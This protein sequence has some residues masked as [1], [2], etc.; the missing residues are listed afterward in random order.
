MGGKESTQASSNDKNKYV[1]RTP[2]EIR[3]I[4]SQRFKPQKGEVKNTQNPQ[5]DSVPIIENIQKTK[6]EIKEK[7]DF[8]NIKQEILEKPKESKH[9]LINKTPENN[10]LEV[11][12]VRKLD[13]KREINII[14]KREMMEKDKIAKIKKEE[15]KLENIDSI[16]KEEVAKTEELIKE[17]EEKVSK[18]EKP[19]EEIIKSEIITQVQEETKDI[20][21]SN[22]NQKISAKKEE[23]TTADESSNLGN[24]LS[25]L[26]ENTK[27]IKIQLGTTL[28]DQ[29]S[30][31][32]FELYEENKKINKALED[33]FRVSLDPSKKNQNKRIKNE[34]EKY[35]YL[36][37]LLQEKKNALNDSRIPP[38][39]SIQ[40]DESIL[41][42]RFEKTQN[43]IY[44]YI[45]ID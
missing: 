26:E 2:E 9:K 38:L 21:K 18:E 31:T 19:K 3:A 5:K 23:K 39:L 14:Q 40:D 25:S 20:S 36:D 15:V 8:E 1:A 32:E 16:E 7:V 11:E 44:I 4:R 22:K 41:I 35:I 6:E 12:N 28:K 45:Y 37:G 42:E 24:T 27:S 43:V 30:S 13:E 29:L 17:E 34:Y 10:T 33:I